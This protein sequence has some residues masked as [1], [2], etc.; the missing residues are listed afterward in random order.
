MFA[1]SHTS[2]TDAAGENF[3][4]LNQVENKKDGLTPPAGL[5]G[6]K[7]GDSAHQQQ[8]SSHAAPPSVS[9]LPGHKHAM[10]A[11]APN[12]APPLSRLSSSVSSLSTN[13][14]EEGGNSLLASKIREQAA[15]RAR[16]NLARKTAKEETTERN[17]GGDDDATDQGPG[18]EREH[19][20]EG[21]KDNMG[22][23]R[24]AESELL[25]SKAAES[26]VSSSTGRKNAF[27]ACIICVF[28][29]IYVQYRT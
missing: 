8:A 24:N 5:A 14:R 10:P 26:L 21:S 13:M 28:V 7:N 27:C 19:H 4:F 25:P 20:R 18:V 9:A 2:R 15:K 3:L 17:G 23:M 6:D 22:S 12:A 1:P 16:E 11:T 29:C